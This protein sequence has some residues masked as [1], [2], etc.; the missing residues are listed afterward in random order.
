MAINR[1]GPGATRKRV[2]I[3]YRDRKMSATEIAR[4]LRVSDA[5]VY[6]HLKQL[7]EEG[8][9]PERGRPGDEQHVAA[10]TT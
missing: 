6:F 5:N 1:G 10:E 8:K 7:R 2:L 9:L 4:K 3:L